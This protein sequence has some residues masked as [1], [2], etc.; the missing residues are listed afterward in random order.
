MAWGGGCDRGGG[1]GRGDGGVTVML[2]GQASI[3][4]IKQVSDR[5]VSGRPGSV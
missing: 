1:R 2:L 5:V 3:S 4:V